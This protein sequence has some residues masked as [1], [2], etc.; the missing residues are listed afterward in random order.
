MLISPVCIFHSICTTGDR[1]LNRSRVDVQRLEIVENRRIKICRAEIDGHVKLQLEQRR[2][3]VERHRAV[4]VQALAARDAL[5][6]L[7]IETGK[8]RIGQ[9]A[10]GDLGIGLV[11]RIG[12]A[13]PLE[14]DDDH[15]ESIA[16]RVAQPDRPRLNHLR[17]TTAR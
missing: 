15:R 9:Q 4:N 8:S 12:A 13:V 16:R 7:A 10:V 17:A 11:Q 5:D 6:Q 3:I 2:F 14:G 1:D